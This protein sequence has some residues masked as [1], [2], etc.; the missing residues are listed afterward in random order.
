MIILT[1]E[2]L[3]YAQNDTMRRSYCVILEPRAAKDLI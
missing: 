1:I 3:H 2:I